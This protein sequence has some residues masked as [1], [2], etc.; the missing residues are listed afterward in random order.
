MPKAFSK[1]FKEVQTTLVPTPSEDGVSKGTV[2]R[3]VRDMAMD[4]HASPLLQVRRLCCAVNALGSDL[5][6]QG[7]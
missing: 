5:I 2:Q 1:K 6:S 3:I 4:L 7:D